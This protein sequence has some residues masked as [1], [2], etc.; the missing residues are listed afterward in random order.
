VVRE[1]GY[2]VSMAD[3][4]DVPAGAAQPNTDGDDAWTTTPASAGSAAAT[5]SD[6]GRIAISI[7]GAPAIARDITIRARVTN[8]D[9]TPAPLA[10][11][12]GMA[13]HA[14][15]VRTDGQV[16]MHLHPMGTSSMAAQQRLLRREAGDTVN[17][18]EAQPVAMP[19]SMPG[20]SMAT[21]DSS[22]H[23]TAAPA[24]IGDVA[25]PVAFP[26]AGSYRVFVQVRRM[27]RAI[28]TAVLDVTI[29]PAPAPR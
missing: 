16:F 5:L 1:S 6:G 13:G 14:M 15:V 11:W 26:S 7:D 22:M 10:P 21:S 4:V 18:G 9:G 23:A 29:P 28:D 24:A 8:A 27:G 19:M 17:H 2:T 20:H 3:T 25:F 12:L